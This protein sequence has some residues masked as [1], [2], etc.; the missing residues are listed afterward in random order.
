[1]TAAD[2]LVESLLFGL[3]AYRLW[4]L[5]ALDTITEPLRARLLR[6]VEPDGIGPWATVAYWLACPWCAGFWIAGAVVLLDG[7]V[8]G[9]SGWALPVWWGCAAVVGLAATLAGDAGNDA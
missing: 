2:A 8:A 4:R 9:W 5:A 1:M 6:R 3:V 7:A